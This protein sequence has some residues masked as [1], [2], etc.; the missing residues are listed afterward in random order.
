[1]GG[2]RRP[3]VARTGRKGGADVIPPGRPTCGAC[4]RRRP[5]RDSCRPARR[6]PRRP[7]ACARCTPRSRPHPRCSTRVRS[8]RAAAGQQPPSGLNAA[9]STLPEWPVKRTNAPDGWRTARYSPGDRDALAAEREPMAGPAL[10][11]SM[12][13]VLPFRRSH[14]RTV[15]S[16]PA[17]S[18]ESCDT[19]HSPVTAPVCPFMQ[20]VFGP[21]VIARPDPDHAVVGAGGDALAVGRDG[22]TADVLGRTAQAAAFGAGGEIPELHAHF[23]GGQ[24]AWRRS[25]PTCRPAPSRG[26]RPRRSRRRMS[27]PPGIC[28]GA[29]GASGRLRPR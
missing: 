29:R 26:D 22:D 5:R 4:R 8:G 15:P 23:A 16:T 27:F 1:M 9:H 10:V 18:S 21:L 20:N 12:P 14:C 24:V 25:P 13:F 3:R 17:E 11:C 2:S 19:N 7:L 28:R 6:R